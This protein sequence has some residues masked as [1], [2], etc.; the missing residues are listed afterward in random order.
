MVSER[1][2]AIIL[3]TAY[4]PGSNKKAKPLTT[5]E[6]NK[7]AIWLNNKKM[8]PE[9][10]LSNDKE[11]ILKEWRDSRITLERINLLLNRGAVMAI[12][13]DK[14][15][16]SGVWVI[17]RSDIEYPTEIRKKLNH[18]SPP[19][20]YG[21]GNSKILKTEALGVVGS[22]NASEE[23]Y[24]ISFDL[25]KKVANLGFSIVSGGA[26]GID[27]KSMLGSL[28]NEGTCIGIL[29][30]K[31]LKK[32]TSKIYRPHIMNGNLVF[33][34]PYNPEAGFNVGNA[35]ARNKFIYVKSK[36]TVVIHSGLKGGTWT[37]AIENL[38]NKWVPVWV[39]QNDDQLSGNLELIKKG[40][41]SLPQN[42]SEWQMDQV[43]NS[44]V[45]HSP[46]PDLFSTI[47]EPNVAIKKINSVKTSV[48]SKVKIKTENKMLSAFFELLRSDYPNGFNK[49][50]IVKD[51]NILPSQVNKWLKEL[52]SLSYLE[53]ISNDRFKIL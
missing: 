49:K 25:G 6:W 8:I 29:A 14:W 47:E 31:L 4:L 41:N 13:L 33:I 16:R 52:E 51:Y 18:L 39:K 44:N 42:F 5:T 30:D 1:S 23:D 35:M 2:K 34:S 28:E 38:K 22:R 10:L 40:A 48:N 45:I 32:S 21:I 53:I 7:L 43:I 11:E 9:D 37:G 36:A 17:N 50:E 27:E 46:S 24:Q 12:C 3:L 20:F 26:K 15:E 19:I